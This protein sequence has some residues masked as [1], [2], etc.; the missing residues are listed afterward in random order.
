MWTNTCVKQWEIGSVDNVSSSLNPDRLKMTLDTRKTW[1]IFLSFYLK[2]K[3]VSL[4]CE[5]L[6]TINLSGNRVTPRTGRTLVCPSI[7]V[8]V[9]MSDPKDGGVR[10]KKKW[11]SKVSV[12]DLSQLIPHN[13]VE[14]YLSP[15]KDT[16]TTFFKIN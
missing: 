12:F 13:P 11:S 16:Y 2:T 3:I 4:S 8:L 10:Q 1:V 7:L 15:N 14:F 5:Y 9:L 6:T